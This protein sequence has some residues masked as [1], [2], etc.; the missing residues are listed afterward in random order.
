[1]R[2]SST[3]VLIGFLMAPGGCSSTAALAPPSQDLKRIMEKALNPAATEIA[4]QLFHHR[5]AP[6]G[7]RFG[8]MAARARELSD[9]ARG[10]LERIPPKHSDRLDDYREF[11]VMLRH[12]SSGLLESATERNADQAVLWYWHVKN[13]CA[14]CHRIYRF[15]EERPLRGSVR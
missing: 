11:A 8:R 3:A 2:A 9:L 14:S 7:E 6:E 4:F 1:M 5:Q 12:Y 13:T 10:V 15:A